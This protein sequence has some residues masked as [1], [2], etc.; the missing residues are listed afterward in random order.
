MRKQFLETCRLGLPSL[1]LALAVSAQSA[2]AQTTINFVCDGTWEAFEMNADGTQGTSLGGAV[3][4]TWNTYLPLVP[5]V[6][7]MWRPD[8]DGTT[9]SDLQGVY[10][11]KQFVLGVPSSGQI[12]V[13][14]D[15]FAEVQ[16][17]GHVVG[18]T[19]SLT[20]FNAAL[21]AQSAL[22]AFDLLAYL[23][24]GSNTITVKAQNGVASFAGGIC[25]P[26][27][28]DQN[29]AGVIFTG[30]LTYEGVTAAKRGTWGNV[31]A[32]YR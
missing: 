26:C 17:N 5:G 24:V 4:E 9:L 25:N 7:W 8:V 29:H 20:V 12:S 14:A 2:A 30:S 1:L 22:K 13:G 15:D 23:V 19:G 16:V 6:C 3:C 21:A 27:N 10:L 28:Y 31:K 11:S 32:H 18:S